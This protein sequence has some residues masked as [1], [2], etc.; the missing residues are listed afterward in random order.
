[1]QSAKNDF[2]TINPFDGLLP[3]WAFRRTLVYGQA[4]GL[5]HDEIEDGLLEVAVAF[6]KFRFDDTRKTA[7]KENTAKHALIRNLM[8]RVLRSRNRYTNLIE[9]TFRD[10]SRSECGPDTLASHALWQVVRD[11]PKLERDVCVLLSSGQNIHSIAKE[12]N[13]SWHTIERA[14]ARIKNCFIEGGID[15]GALK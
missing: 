6:S 11:M 13:V 12:L 2:P 3:Q 5:N 9:R 10:V 7:A 4:I 1:M 14:I 8:N 15:G